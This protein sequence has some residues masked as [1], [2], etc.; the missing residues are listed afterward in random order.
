MSNGAPDTNVT[1]SVTAASVETDAPTT[2][3]RALTPILLLASRR[4]NSLTRRGKHASHNDRARRTMIRE[5]TPLPKKE[6][7]DQL[8]SWDRP[9]QGLFRGTS[10]KG[11]SFQAVD[12]RRW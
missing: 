5:D 11:G 3:T 1:R 4:D 8:E 10:T 12:S 9:L 6:S 2:K 7:V